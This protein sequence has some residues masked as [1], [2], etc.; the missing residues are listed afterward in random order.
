[1]DPYLALA[2]RRAT[3]ARLLAVLSLA[4]L[5]PGAA[6]RAGSF[7]TVDAYVSLASPDYPGTSTQVV[8]IIQV[9]ASQ[10]GPGWYFYDATFD[11]VGWSEPQ[12]ASFDFWPNKFFSMVPLRGETGPVDVDFGVF[13]GDPFGVAPGRYVIEVTATVVQY[14]DE[15]FHEVPSAY[16]TETE[17]IVF[18]IPAPEP[19]ATHAPEPS[20]AVMGGIAALGGLA[21]AAAR[22]RRAG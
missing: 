6:A 21:L 17:S 7:L 18:T 11:E 19:P 1:V 10:A 8:P 12:L 3:T 2:A 20:A 15:Y 22:R 13:L 14:A 4:I 5:A 9:D 16:R